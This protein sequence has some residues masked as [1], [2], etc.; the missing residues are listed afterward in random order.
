MLEHIHRIFEDL[1]ATTSS[2]EKLSTL[3]TFESPLLKDILLYANNPFWQYNLTSKQV[4]K[5]KLPVFDINPYESLEANEQ[6]IFRMFNDLRNRAFTGNDAIRLYY[7]VID[8]CKLTQEDI[9]LVDQILDKD[10]QIRLGVTLVNK[11]FPNLLPV[12]ECKLAFPI[13]DGDVDF[14]ECH[15]WLAS[16]KLDGARL[17]SVIN[18]DGDI[19]FFSREGKEFETLGKVKTNLQKF[20][21]KGWVIDG[22][23]CIVDA[24][25]LEQFQGIMSELGR[26]N[27]T[28]ENPKYMIFDMIPYDVFFGISND[29]DR[30][31]SDRFAGFSK[32]FDDEPYLKVVEQRTF[33]SQAELD[34][35][36]SE[37]FSKGWEGLILQKDVTYDECRGRT[38]NLLK[39][40][41]FHDSEYIVAG[42]VNGMIR[43]VVN[44]VEVTEEMLSSIVIIHKDCEV[45][46]GSGFTME[47]RKRFY[48]H[49]E[50]IIGR[51]VTIKYQGESSNKKGGFSLRFPVLKYIYD[52]ERTI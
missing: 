48:E 30:K 25:G 14:N 12:F 16:R 44:H 41:K 2:K 32:M 23:I 28:I 33:N 7:T 4:H 43:R 51:T 8:H 24:N 19:S 34:A 5:K 45:N 17:L 15:K 21:L 46:V 39:I 26:K 3:Q 31:F 20:G 1:R 49:P 35:M 42:T 27:H 38:R 47:Q 52:G 18:Y 37:A 22:E 6:M 50:E 40:K 9:K 36:A 13:E 29:D 10:L 11:A